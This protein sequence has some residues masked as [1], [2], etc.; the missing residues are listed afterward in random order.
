VRVTAT[1]RRRCRTLNREVMCALFA[2][3]NREILNNAYRIGAELE[4]EIAKG[5]QL[6]NGPIF[7]WLRDSRPM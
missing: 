3:R 1:Y 7:T 4:H 5:L 2:R 6:S